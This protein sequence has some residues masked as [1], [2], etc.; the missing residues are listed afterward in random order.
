MPTNRD[1]LYKIFDEICK[2][3]ILHGIDILYIISHIRYKISDIIC[4]YL[5]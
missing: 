5:I 2:I 1:Y 4:R 3:S